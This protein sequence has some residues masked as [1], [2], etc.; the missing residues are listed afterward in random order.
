MR[1]LII[2]QIGLLLLGNYSNAQQALSNSGNLQIHT[3]ASISGFG[4]FTNNSSGV[5]INNGSFNLKGNI[6]N[7]QSAM[8]AGTGTL[9]LN[10]S[11]AQSVS[12]SQTLKTYDLVSDNTAGITL[13]NNLS[14]SNTHTFTNGIITSS[15]TPNYLVYESGS[16]YSGSSDAKHVNGWVKKIGSTD[17]IFPLGNGTYLRPVAIEGLS[18]SSEFNAR[19]NMP[20]PNVYQLQNPLLSVDVYEYWTVNKISGGSASVHLN[21]D[22]TKVTFPGYIM[23]DMAVSFFDGSYWTDQGGSA[24]GNVATTGDITSNPVSSFGNFVIGSRSFPLPLNFLSFT[25]QRGE[26][27]TNLKWVTAE[28]VN[29]DHFEIQRSENGVQFIS[30][31]S[32]PTAN[33]FTTQ[34]YTYKDFFVFSGVAYYRIKCVDK[35]GKSKFSRIATVYESSWLHKPIK[36]LNPVDNEIIILSQA[37]DKEA[38]AYILYNQAGS[39]ILKGWLKLKGGMDNTIRLFFKPAKGVYFLKLI[40]GN[41]E[42]I[43][44]LVI[45]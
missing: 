12:G 14:V 9:Y 5:L 37:D 39:A 22:N 38:T 18:G 4:N 27:Y 25:A 17:F 21:W 20:T 40:R 43:E 32:M 19:Y 16:A 26:G 13:N 34:E 7:D 30:L 35:D 33:R 3:G 36:V 29:T 2:I 8:S 45:N 1:K 42:I 41:K 15:A 28:E 24:S 6:T 11:V 31:A 44:K 23:G 10:G